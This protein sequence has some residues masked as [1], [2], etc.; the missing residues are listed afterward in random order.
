[1]STVHLYAYNEGNR[2]P[3][4]DPQMRGSIVGL[5]LVNAYKVVFV[6]ND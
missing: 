6:L 5:E 1:M 4:A 3:V 2:S